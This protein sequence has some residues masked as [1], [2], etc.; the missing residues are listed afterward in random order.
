[1]AQTWNRKI[2]PQSLEANGLELHVND[3]HDL[4]NTR[5][6]WIGPRTRRQ[7]KASAI[8]IKSTCINQQ[9]ERKWV[10]GGFTRMAAAGQISGNSQPGNFPAWVPADAAAQPPAR[11]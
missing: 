6:E 7:Q 3:P 11:H 8:V 4:P 9:Q 10:E 1:M 2:I 5:A